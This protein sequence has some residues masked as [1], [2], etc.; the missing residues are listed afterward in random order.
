MHCYDGH[1]DRNVLLQP[2]KDTDSKLADNRMEQLFTAIEQ[3]YGTYNA[4][5][6]HEYGFDAKQ[7]EIIR[8]KYLED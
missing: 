8:A 2:I 5:F 4:Y 6:L 1:T 7:I 3:K